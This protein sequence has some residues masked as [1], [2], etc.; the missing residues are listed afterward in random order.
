MG[1]YRTTAAGAAE[2]SQ[3][4]SRSQTHRQPQ[5]HVRNSVCAQNGSALGTLAA[6]TRLGIGDD[7]LASL[8]CLAAKRNLEGDPRGSL[9]SFTGGGS[10]RLVKGDRRFFLGPCHARGKKTGPNPT[11]RRKSGSKHH[12]ATDANG[13]PLAATL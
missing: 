10:T 1:Y 12:L 8:A 6:G 9:G 3:E 2:T 4:A 13:I 5:S 11:D 7:G